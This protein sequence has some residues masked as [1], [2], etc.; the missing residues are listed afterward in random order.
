MFNYKRIE[1]IFNYI[2]SNDYTTAA[3]LSDL[4]KVSERTIRTDINNLN[5][6]LQGAS[7]QL[8]R[9][10]G[11]Y[12]EIEDEDTFNSFLDSITSKET[13]FIDLDSSEDRIRFILNKLLYSHDYISTDE[14]ADLVYVSKN[15]FSNYIKIIAQ[16]KKIV[17]LSYLIQRI[18]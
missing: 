11:Y 9:K 2:R 13:D 16:F 5:N 18:Y 6:E 8:K 17:A 3:K 14:L 4:F 12:L 10:A 1:D 15:T 7:V